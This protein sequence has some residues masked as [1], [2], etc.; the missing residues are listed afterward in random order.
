MTMMTVMS[1]D[2][3]GLVKTCGWR[4]SGG[5]TVLIVMTMTMLTTMTRDEDD[6]RAAPVGLHCS[7]DDDW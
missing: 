2:G 6:V 5:N 4:W 7:D 1:D 3:E